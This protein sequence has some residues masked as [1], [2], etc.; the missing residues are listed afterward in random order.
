MSARNREK[1]DFAFAAQAARAAAA[2]ARKTR[3]GRAVAD[4]NVAEL[5]LCDLGRAKDRH[6]VGRAHHAE[7]LVE[8]RLRVL[9]AIVA[10]QVLHGCL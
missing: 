6:G 10:E 4:A 1:R 2:A 5:L 8:R 9:T 7:Q 3:T